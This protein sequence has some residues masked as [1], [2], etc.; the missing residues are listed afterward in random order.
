MLGDFNGM[1]A[2]SFQRDIRP[3]SMEPADNN[4]GSAGVAVN[5]ACRLSG[6]TW[7]VDSRCSATA[8]AAQRCRAR[9]RLPHA[10]GEA[11]RSSAWP[12]MV[13]ALEHEKGGQTDGKCEKRPRGDL[14]PA[15]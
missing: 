4:H 7:R 12:S 15:S 14:R 2:Q 11:Y 5:N 10:L 9:H 8:T 3:P 1:H 13:H 6:C